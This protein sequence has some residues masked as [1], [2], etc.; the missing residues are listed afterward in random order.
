MS[1]PSV[2][3]QLVPSG[4]FGAISCWFRLHQQP[5][6]RDFGD[7]AGSEVRMLAPSEQQFVLSAHYVIISC[8]FRHQQAPTG[9]FGHQSG[10][11]GAIPCWFRKKTSTKGWFQAPSWPPEVMLASSEHKSLWLGQFVAISCWF[12]HKTSTGGFRHAAGHLR[13]S[14][15]HLNTNWFHMA[16]LLP[17]HADS[18]TNQ[19]SQVVSDTKLAIW[20]EFGSIW[21]PIGPIRPLCCHSRLTQAPTS[22]HRWFFQGPNWP[23]E[24][25]SAQCEHKL[26]HQAILVPFHA[27]SCLKLPNSWLAVKLTLQLH[28]N[29]Q[30]YDTIS[31]YLDFLLRLML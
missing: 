16:T 27:D 18:G 14:L 4:H 17:L 9:G 2:E 7:Q 26:V 29:G 25:M 13:W 22:T 1:A 10:P 28:L 23:C 3:H 11:L 5:P 6:T 12:R 8:W 15:V 20:G 19:H 31:S 21:T 24:V 30:K